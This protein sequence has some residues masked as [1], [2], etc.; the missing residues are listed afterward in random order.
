MY[1]IIKRFFLREPCLASECAQCPYTEIMYTK[2]E[3]KAIAI[4]K[5]GGVPCGTLNR[6]PTTTSHASQAIARVTLF[7]FTVFAGASQRN[8]PGNHFSIIA[9]WWVLLPLLN[10][11]LV[12]KL[13]G[14]QPTVFKLRAWIAQ[15]AMVHISCAVRN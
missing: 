12:S 14:C 7:V 2:G 10:R 8:R 5:K 9:R 11:V 6:G 3:E 1:K 15:S 4:S 13:E